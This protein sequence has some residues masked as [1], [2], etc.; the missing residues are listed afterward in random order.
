LLA[1]SGVDEIAR[2]EA[3]RDEVVADREIEQRLDQPRKELLG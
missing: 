2:E 1:E 3:V